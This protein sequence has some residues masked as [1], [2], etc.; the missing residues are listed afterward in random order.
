MSTLPLFALLCACSQ[1]EITKPPVAYNILKPPPAGAY[2]GDAETT[3]RT[4]AKTEKGTRELS[5]VD[6]T[7]TTP[8]TES[9]FQTPAHVTTPNLGAS[10]PT[11]NLKCSDGT[12]SVQKNLRAENLSLEERSQRARASGAGA[13]VIGIIVGGVMAGVNEGRG[14]RPDDVHGYSATWLN[15]DESKEPA[16]K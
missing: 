10:T 7:L 11:A 4:G 8:Y 6:C 16:K 1:A 13:G 15:M 12:R 3:I 2:R 14:D 9:R 5:G